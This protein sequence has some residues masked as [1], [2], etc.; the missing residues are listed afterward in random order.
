MVSITSRSKTTRYH[1]SGLTFRICLEDLP[2]RLNRDVQ[3]PADLTFLRPP[4]ALQRGTGILT[5]FPSTTLFSLALG[6]DSPCADERCQETFFGFR[7]GAFHS[8]IATHVSIRTSD[9]SSILLKPPSTAYR[10]LSYHMCKYI[11]A[12]SV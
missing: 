8:F 7:R 1:A 2:T 6:A 9:T 5:C 4:I 10:T 12:I 11:S 3:H